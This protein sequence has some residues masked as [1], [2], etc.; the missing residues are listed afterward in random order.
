MLIVS[1]P[2]MRH[3]FTP[4]KVALLSGLSDPETC[5]LSR[6]QTDFLAALQVPESWKVYRNFPYAP[7]P[8][9]AR[10]EP[11]LWLASLRNLR[12]FLQAGRRP[13]RDAAR[14]HWE[15]LAESAGELVIVTLSCGLEILNH[16]LPPRGRNGLHVFALGPVARE[17]P[18][19]ACTLL[20][21]ARDYLSKL[22]FRTADVV[23]PGVGHMDYLGNPEVFQRINEYLCSSISRSSGPACP[24][25][26]AS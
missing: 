15:A 12:Q 19:A 22:F 10:R 2:P 26:R 24:C 21:G 9:G 1:Q 14:R 25:R 7:C 3:P 20:Q 23:L 6:V 8:A 17:P 18:R 16:C 5:A 4:V 13:Y 11:P